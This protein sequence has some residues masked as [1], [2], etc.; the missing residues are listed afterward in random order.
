MQSRER[1]ETC[2]ATIIRSQI[3]FAKLIRTEELD[4]LSGAPSISAPRIANNG[5]YP[6]LWFTQGV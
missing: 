3:L 4:S 1:H 5:L 2:V 6:L